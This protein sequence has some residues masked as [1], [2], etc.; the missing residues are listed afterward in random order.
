MKKM[1]LAAIIFCAGIGVMLFAL[2]RKCDDE[3]YNS[4]DNDWDEVL[5]NDGI[6][7]DPAAQAA[8]SVSSAVF[9]IIRPLRLLR[10]RTR[11]RQ[12]PR[13]PGR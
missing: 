13:Y 12:S 8:G 11:R 3:D 1:F 6:E 9:R 10:S 2:A 4:E 5:K 7:K